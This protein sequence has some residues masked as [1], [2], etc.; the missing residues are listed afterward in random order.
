M[1]GAFIHAH[2]AKLTP[3]KLPA[4][5]TDQMKSYFSSRVLNV[6]SQV[7]IAWCSEALIKPNITLSE[8]I[9]ISSKLRSY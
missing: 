4:S 8:H 3:E 2:Q 9:W 5:W 7:K 6:T 1:Q